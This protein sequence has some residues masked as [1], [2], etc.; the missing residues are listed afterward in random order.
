ML[1]HGERLTM[2]EAFDALRGYARA[3]G[4]TLR[5]AAERTVRREATSA[6]IVAGYAAEPAAE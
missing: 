5:V 4:I 6:E 1:S 2:P 3:N